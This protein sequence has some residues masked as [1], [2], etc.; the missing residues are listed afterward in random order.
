[1][2]TKEI[3]VD[4]EEKVHK[5]E[6]LSLRLWKRGGEKPPPTP[7]PQKKNGPAGIVRTERTN[8]C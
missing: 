1:M 5:P 6:L 8:I 2:S 4:D 3:H 7:I